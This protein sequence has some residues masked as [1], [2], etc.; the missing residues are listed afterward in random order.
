MHFGNLSDGGI[1]AFGVQPALT[2]GDAS[3]EYFLNSLDPNGTT[4]NRLGVWALTDGGA[5]ARGDIPELSNVVIHSETY[6]LPPNAVQKGS[7]S[8]ITT[9]DDRMQQ[10]EYINGA[11]WGE[12]STAFTVN[13]DS[14]P[15][16]AAAWFEVTPH[17]DGQVIGGAKVHAQGYVAVG[18]A[19]CITP[20]FQSLLP[21]QQLW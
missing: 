3:A 16:A 19:S 9:D 1:Q 11:I 7:T 6:G 8:L 21:V 4:D 5:V 2:Y 17:L 15:I 10:V 20:R 13:G 14:T 12:L 18:A